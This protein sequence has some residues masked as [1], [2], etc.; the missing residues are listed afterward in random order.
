MAKKTADP[1][2]QV[3]VIRERDPGVEKWIEKC[4]PCI[5]SKEHGTIPFKP[6]P[7]QV[8]LLH[9][10]VE[11]GV[12]MVKKSRQIG[13][14][15]TLEVGS[16]YLLLWRKPFHMHYVSSTDEKTKRMIY[17]TRLALAT[18][19]LP[20]HQRA[21]LNLGPDNKMMITYRSDK[22]ENYIQGHAP[23]PKLTGYPGNAVLMDEV[24]NMPYAERIYKGFGGMLSDGWVTEWLV[25]HPDSDGVSTRFFNELWDKSESKELNIRAFK[26]DW[27][28]K[29]GRDLNWLEE[30][31]V[32]F[33]GREDLRD[34]AHCCLDI[35]PA[36]MAFDPERM[37]KFAQATEYIGQWSIPG[38]NYTLGVDQSGAGASETIGCVIDVSVK[39]AQVVSV[40]KF[41]M[42][43]TSPEGRTT[44]KALWIDQT[45][46]E[47]P[48]QVL[49]DSTNQMGTIENVRL[50]QKI[51]VRITGQ[52]QVTEKTQDGVRQLMW[53][54]SKLIDNAVKLTD[55][56]VVVVHQDRFPE[57]YEAFK[58]AKRAVPGE[59]IRK[60]GKN[61]DH[62]DAFLL[63]CV[64]L[65]G[66]G[67]GVENGGHG[68]VMSRPRTQHKK[69]GHL[70]RRKAYPWDSGRKV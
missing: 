52:T 70:H 9:W 28:A 1:A 19:E 12:G 10:L 51:A 6:W 7:T 23:I 48:G 35:Q 30:Q 63:A 21:N 65:T 33:G 13:F 41:R 27:R 11:G 55:T 4:K 14:T 39:P 64:P 50:R 47:F 26:A 44:Q 15:T 3:R 36:D 22:T 40:R 59:R 61:I 54:R 5:D 68:R 60:V 18:A 24:V 37:A 31:L 46:S 53:P 66:R 56:G 42:D 29:P 43:A 38:H 69:P 16:A 25:S 57:L 62:L 20:D 17:E 45:G 58:T 67:M 34:E 2:V 8:A 32:M 49:L